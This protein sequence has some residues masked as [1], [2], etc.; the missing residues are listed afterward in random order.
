MRLQRPD[1]LQG[2]AT[3]NPSFKVQRCFCENLLGPKVGLGRGAF[4]RPYQLMAM[5]VPKA[6][7]S[8]KGTRMIVENFVTSSM[9]CYL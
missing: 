8:P 2:F 3:L 9:G 5:I 4:G 6:N 1:S 7:V